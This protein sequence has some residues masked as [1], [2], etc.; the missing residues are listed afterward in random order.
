MLIKLLRNPSSNYGCNLLEGQTGN[1]SSELGEMLL[2][3][4][5]ALRI[6]QEPEK[7]K[8]I[9]GVA[10]TPAIAKEIKPA[11]AELKDLPSE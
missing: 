8:R 6:E 5:I 7:P 3:I 2:R 1:V 11:I 4:G 9:K 10:K